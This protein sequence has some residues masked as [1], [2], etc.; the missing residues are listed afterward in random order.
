M[1]V[2]RYTQLLLLK[3]KVCDQMHKR[4]YLLLIN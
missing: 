3:K 4:I 1:S 2:S